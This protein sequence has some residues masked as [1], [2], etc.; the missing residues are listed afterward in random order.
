M[1]THADKASETKSTSMANGSPKRQPNGRAAVQL[2]DNRPEATALMKMQEL[3]NDSPQVSQ[4]RALQQLANNSQQVSQSRSLQQLANNSP[5]AKQASQLQALADATT[6]LPIQQKIAIG[7]AQLFQESEEE[8]LMQAKPQTAQRQPSATDGKP[9]PNNTGLPDNLK[10]GI[11]ALSG[12]SLD[13]VKVHYNSAQPAQLNA[14][15]YAQGSDIHLAPGQEQHLPHE[16]WHIVQQAQGRV[17]PTVQM[18]DGV[19]VNDDAGLER[20]A[21]VMGGKA[22]Q[23]GGTQASAVQRQAIAPNFPSGQVVDGVVQA[24]QHFNANHQSMALPGPAANARDHAIDTVIRIAIRGLADNAILND[25]IAAINLA[26]QHDFLLPGLNM[27]FQWNGDEV[28]LFDTANNARLDLLGRVQD[29]QDPQLY[30]AVNTGTASRL[31]VNKDTGE[32]RV[33]DA[34]RRYIPRTIARSITGAERTALSHRNAMRPRVPNAGLT[35]LE[36][37]SGGQM[38][39]YTSYSRAPGDVVNSHG[40]LFNAGGTG[41]VNIDLLHIAMA[42]ILDLSTH[43]GINTHLRP[44]LPQNAR[45]NFGAISAAAKNKADNEVA[46]GIVNPAGTTNP[47]RAD[48]TDQRWQALVDA[49]RTQE[50]LVQGDVPFDAVTSFGEYTAALNPLA[51]LAQQGIADHAQAFTQHSQT[52]EA[53]LA[54]HRNPAAPVLPAPWLAVVTAVTHALDASKNEF[55]FKHKAQ[56]VPRAKERN[57]AFR[58]A[59]DRVHVDVLAKVMQVATAY[60]TR[61]QAN[62]PNSTLVDMTNEVTNRR[63]G[64]IADLAGVMP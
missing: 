35:P 56:G 29:D 19:P 21:D 3:A 23:M 2:A 7:I 32:E 45:A 53:A 58:L 30:L 63:A 43:E 6:P 26:A 52:G 14:L 9:R 57:A 20:E 48:L 60:Y 1:N 39:Q 34:A 61:F 8:E 47:H 42:N 44:Q 49:Y 64:W 17:E 27:A 25:A 16:A 22:L 28:Y 13:H 11:E 51:A 12:M 54:A 41:R 40:E 37:V 4:L 38:S 24:K 36:H 55:L 10:S 46:N 62:W 59:M 50:V 31:Q 5:Q 33:L 15:A 18:K